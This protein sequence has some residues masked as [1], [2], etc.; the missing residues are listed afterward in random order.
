[1]LENLCKL[2][3]GPSAVALEQGLLSDIAFITGSCRNR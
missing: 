3:I 2:S 1:M